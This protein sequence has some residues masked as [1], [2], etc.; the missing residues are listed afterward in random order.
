MAQVTSTYTARPWLFALKDQGGL[1]CDWD[2]NQAFEGTFGIIQAMTPAKDF[3]E[4]L[5][6]S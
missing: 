3:T 2:E 6:F 4:Q 5:H 1:C